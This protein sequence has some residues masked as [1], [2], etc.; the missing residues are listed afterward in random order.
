MATPASAADLKPGMVVE[1]RVLRVEPTRVV[2]EILGEEATLTWERITP[3]VPEWEREDL[4][5]GGAT[6]RVQIKDRN[7]A[8]RLQAA[9]RRS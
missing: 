3:P 4:F 6:I 8:G 7:K 1:A 2:L 5:A 9:M